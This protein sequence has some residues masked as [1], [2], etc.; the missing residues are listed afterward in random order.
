MLLTKRNKR[1]RKNRTLKKRL[2]K[3][4]VYG[5]VFSKTCRYCLLMKNEWVALKKDKKISKLKNCDIGSDYIRKISEFNNKYGT[6]LE[7][8]GVPTIFKLNKKGEDIMYYPST[9]PKKKG[10]I[11]KWIMAP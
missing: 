3:P 11:K 5:Y 2:K 10:L 8:E 9:E 6:N 7:V 4:I 1:T